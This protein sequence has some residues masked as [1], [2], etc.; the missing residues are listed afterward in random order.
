V[1]QGSSKALLLPRTSG[2]RAFLDNP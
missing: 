2:T 1:G